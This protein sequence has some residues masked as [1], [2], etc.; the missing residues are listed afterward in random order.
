MIFDVIEPRNPQPYVLGASQDRFGLG[1]CGCGCGGGRTCSSI[2]VADSD[3]FFVDFPEGTRSIADQINAER[4]GMGLVA[5]GAL[6]L[7]GYLVGRAWKG[8]RR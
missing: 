3:R 7:A 8:R 2:V 4:G 6:G 1:D 5:L